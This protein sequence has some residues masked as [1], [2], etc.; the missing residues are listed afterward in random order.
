VL[1]LKS[2]LLGVQK[3]LDD[4]KTANEWKPNKAFEAKLEGAVIKLDLNAQKWFRDK[5]SVD[6]EVAGKIYAFYGGVAE[7]RNMF[8]QHASSAL[9]DDKAYTKAGKYAGLEEY[10]KFATAEA[11]IKESDNAFLN[12]EFR[13]G[14]L[15]QVPT[16][17][18]PAP[19]GAK[20]VEIGPPF[21]GGDTSP[22]TSGKCPEDKPL[23][24]FAYRA[25]PGAPWASAPGAKSA[26]D[27]VAKSI[28]ITLPG[29]VRESLVKS[30]G[31]V[32]SDVYYT[33]RLLAMYERLRGKP[34]PKDPERKPVGGLVEEGNKLETSIKTILDQKKE[35][36]TFFM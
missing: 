22:N 1:A 6:A 27:L 21:C 5:S 12:G 30:S 4:W 35:R 8:A 16:E 28:V 7:I 9:Y 10:N 25:D 13:Y 23:S 2:S 24:G 36:F 17:K 15:V 19:F 32:A 14:V 3:V 26:N 33:K 20:L 11:Q 18:D 34:D 31:F 29:G